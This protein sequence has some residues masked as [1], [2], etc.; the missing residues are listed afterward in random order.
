MVNGATKMPR[1]VIDNKQKKQKKTTTRAPTPTLPVAPQP[2]NVDP[3]STLLDSTK[4]TLFLTPRSYAFFCR[5]PTLPRPRPNFTRRNIT[6]S[7][8][9]YAM[10]MNMRRAKAAAEGKGGQRVDTGA[11]GTEKVRLSYFAGIVECLTNCPL[12]FSVV[13]G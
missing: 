11:N 9:M 8:E 3:T 2:A 4:R 7:P 5:F 13:T 12:L 10:Y 6:V 1:H